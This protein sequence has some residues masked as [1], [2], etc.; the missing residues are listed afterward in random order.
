MRSVNDYGL[1][2]IQMYNPLTNEE[3]DSVILKYINNHRRC[4]GNPF[5]LFTSRICIRKLAY[6]C[7][8]HVLILIIMIHVARYLICV[9]A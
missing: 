8:N 5:A 2:N 9:R 7:T 1:S 6:F 3:L 4:W